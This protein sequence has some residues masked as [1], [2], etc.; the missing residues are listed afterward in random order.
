MPLMCIFSTFSMLPEYN[1]FAKTKIH[2]VV[3]LSQSTKF[4]FQHETFTAS[5]KQAF[6]PRNGQHKLKEIFTERERECCMRKLCLCVQK[7]RRQ[8]P[9]I[10]WRKSWSC[11]TAKDCE[12]DE[13]ECIGGC[14]GEWMIAQ[15][16]KRKFTFCADAHLNVIVIHN[17]RQ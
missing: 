6:N 15:V 13:I 5:N 1:N 4:N 10:K 3:C 12:P 7:K 2:T 17:M 16:P 14:E 9:L 8:S 11:G